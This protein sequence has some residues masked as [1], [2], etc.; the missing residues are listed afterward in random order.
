[1]G[2]EVP[3]HLVPVMVRTL[4]LDNAD[5]NFKEYCLQHLLGIV[6]FFFYENITV[7][8]LTYLSIV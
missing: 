2:S 4:A 8:K 1:M 6:I 7:E 3:S 5:P